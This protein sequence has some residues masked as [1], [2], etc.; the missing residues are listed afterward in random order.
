MSTMLS[1]LAGE[2]SGR[3]FR[4]RGMPRLGIRPAI[5]RNMS[6]QNAELLGRSFLSRMARKAKNVARKTTH[7]ALMPARGVTHAALTIARVPVNMVKAPF[8]SDSRPS[9]ETA[10]PSA[11]ESVRP[12][13]EAAASMPPL[14]SA[15]GQ[16]IASPAAPGV[17]LPR[18]PMPAPM[19]YA[20]SEPSGY[21]PDYDEGGDDE[22]GDENGEG[23]LT[24][25][26]LGSVSSFFKNSTHNVLNAGRKGVRVAKDAQSGLNS[27]MNMFSPSTDAAGVPTTNWLPIVAV[28]GVLGLG[29]V[30]ILKSRK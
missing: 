18:G 9:M 6:G 25:E 17:P 2:Q 23:A 1:V 8:Q 21:N 5:R 26:T 28:A 16:V 24:E 14:V 4:V 30:F 13:T 20:T 29:A 27:V 7:I 12:A 10:A 22:G 3:N 15:T 11:I 19:Q